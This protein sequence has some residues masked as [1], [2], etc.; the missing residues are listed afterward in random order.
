VYYFEISN[1]LSCIIL[2]VILLLLKEKLYLEFAL[3]LSIEYLLFIFVLGLYEGLNRLT[4][5]NDKLR[6]NNY[7]LHKKNRNRYGISK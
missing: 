5:E 3:I 6:E 1:R 7:F 2:G 4:E